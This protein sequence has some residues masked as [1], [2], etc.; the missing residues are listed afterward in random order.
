M[1]SIS[2]FTLIL[3]RPHKETKNSSVQIVLDCPL[4]SVNVLL[5]MRDVDPLSKKCFSGVRDCGSIVT[6]FSPPPRIFS[7]PPYHVFF[8]DI[9]CNL[10]LEC[11]NKKETS[12]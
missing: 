1:S 12:K 6:S 4:L 3:Y 7:V 2:F 5:Y 9:P 8:Q 10:P 11:N